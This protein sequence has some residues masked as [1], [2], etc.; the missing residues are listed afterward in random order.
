MASNSAEIREQVAKRANGKCEYCQS[1]ERFSISGF[2][3]EHVIPLSKGGFF[4]PHRDGEKLDGMV[5]TLVVTLP[6]KHAGGELIVSHNG[7]RKT[8]K[9]RGAATDCNCSDCKAL[10]RFLDDPQLAS[11]RMPLAKER[12]QHLHRVIDS[13]RLDCLHSTVRVGRPYVL[14][15]TKTMASHDARL[16]TYQRDVKNLARVNRALLQLP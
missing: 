6:T 7:T 15:L 2:S 4:L 1:P 5:A 11:T 14:V 16:K 9:M 8:I 3:I 12:R 10:I 13:K